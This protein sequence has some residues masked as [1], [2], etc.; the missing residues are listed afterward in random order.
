MSLATVREFPLEDEYKKK[1]G[2]TPEDIRKLRAWLKTQPH[3]PE[4]YITDLDLILTFHCSALSTEVTKQLLDLHFTLRTLF[5]NFFKDRA[6]DAKMEFVMEKVLL[7]TPLPTKT[8]EGYGVYYAKFL[9]QDS[10]SFVFA[11]CLRAGLMRL[12]LWQ[13]E[14][15][16]WPGL[17]ILIDLDNMSM[18]HLSKLDL[19]SVQQYA[20]YLQEAQLVNLKGLH[21]LNA[22]AFMDRLLMLVRPFLNKS[23]MSLL[24]IHQAGSKTLDKFFPIED[25]PTGAGGMG[26]S[27]EVLI[28]EN[29]TKMSAAKDYFLAENKKRVTESKRPGKPKTISDI[30]GGVEGSFKKL[31]I[32]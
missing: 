12:D 18:G 20:Y 4:E 31:D 29:V 14:E 13:Y 15:G 23:L 9:S 10:K 3:L 8:P 21:F 7:V 27:I 22:P 17:L 28:K 19:Q 26:K 25:L 11:D 1:T 30:F 24:N 5:T 2:I 16:T 32:D 6:Y